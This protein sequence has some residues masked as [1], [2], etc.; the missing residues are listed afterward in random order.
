M[1]SEHGFYLT[2]PIWALICLHGVT[3]ESVAALTDNLADAFV[4]KKSCTRL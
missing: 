4:H 2:K 3:Q 1:L